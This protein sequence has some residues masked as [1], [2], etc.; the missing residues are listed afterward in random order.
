MKQRR[1]ILDHN[2]HNLVIHKTKTPL[3]FL[4]RDEALSKQNTISIQGEVRMITFNKQG[5]I[6]NAGSALMLNQMLTG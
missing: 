3:Y 5:N 1:A 6:G 2:K 4:N